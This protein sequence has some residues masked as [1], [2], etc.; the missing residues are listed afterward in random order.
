MKIQSDPK[1]AMTLQEAK[2]LVGTKWGRGKSYVHFTG[3]QMC[4]D[5]QWRLETW[6]GNPARVSVC[7]FTIAEAVGWIAKA[8]QTTVEKEHQ[9]E[10]VQ[11]ND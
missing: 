8:T 9:N 10:R 5:G 3:I 7:G 11:D 4:A 1:K 6:Y 2:Q